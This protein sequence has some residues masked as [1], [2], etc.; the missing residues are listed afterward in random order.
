MKFNRIL[1]QYVRESE[2]LTKVRLKVDPKDSSNFDFTHFDGYEGYILRE[3]NG[4]W[5]IL[6]ENV[7]MPIAEVPFSIIKVTAVPDQ[8]TLTKI[9][10]FGLKAIEE[11]KGLT[12]EIISKIQY[13][14]SIEF[15]EQ[16][17]KE[18]GL[19][20][21]EIKDIYKSSLLDESVIEEG[22]W[23]NI[24]KTMKDVAKNAGG[25]LRA[26]YETA[27]DTIVNKTK[28][29]LTYAKENPL[30][31]GLKIAGVGLAAP[32]M[33]DKWIADKLQGKNNPKAGSLFKPPPTKLKPAMRTPPQELPK[34][35][36]IFYYLR[37]PRYFKIYSQDKKSFF[38]FNSNT[39][40]VFY[41]SPASA[42]N[43]LTIRHYNVMS[44]ANNAL[45]SQ[46]SYITT[47]LN[48][49]KSTTAPE[50]DIKFYINALESI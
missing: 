44:R 16:Y 12:M 23:Q 37:N 4:V 36:A 19:T 34:T 39:N 21:S 35:S 47:E 22:V 15:L 43:M 26:G 29:G 40:D 50:T 27:R 42:P 3:N 18:E 13:C 14:E 32:F 33:A 41:V 11:R 31:T 30:K 48:K 10:L 8:N 25:E 7:D 5:S 46:I 17:L 1:E 9:K 20:D 6:F 2:S 49:Q 24:T 45:L 28:E 38:Y